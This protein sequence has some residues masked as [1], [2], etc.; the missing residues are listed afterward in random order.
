MAKGNFSCNLIEK[1]TILFEGPR[2]V[3]GRLIYDSVDYFFTSGTMLPHFIRDYGLFLSFSVL[4]ST[5]L[6]MF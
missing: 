5:M 6:I 3:D 1:L 4:I 2:L